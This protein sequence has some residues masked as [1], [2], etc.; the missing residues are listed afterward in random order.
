MHV[1]YF[2]WF[3]TK[4]EK[5]NFIKTLNES[6]SEVEAINKLMSIYPELKMSEIAGV[7]NNFKNEINKNETK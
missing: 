3:N 2:A 7:V 5:T 4:T 1:R 6:R